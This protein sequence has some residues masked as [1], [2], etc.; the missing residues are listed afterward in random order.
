MFLKSCV[1]FTFTH[2]VYIFYTHIVHTYHPSPGGFTAIFSYPHAYK[3]CTFFYEN[4][5]DT[6]SM[7]S[8]YRGSS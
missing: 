2:F 8:Y 6:S 5:V 3:K 1:F 7:A 4:I